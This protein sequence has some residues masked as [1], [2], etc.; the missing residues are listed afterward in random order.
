MFKA[1][2]KMQTSSFLC[3]FHDIA[4]LE[5]RSDWSQRL[6]T[7]PPASCPW[8]IATSQNWAGIC[9]R[10]PISPGIQLEQI[11]Q[12]L[13]WHL[14]LGFGSV[15]SI[16]FSYLQVIMVSIA[17]IFPWE[18]SLVPG[19]HSEWPEFKELFCWDPGLT[20][21]KLNFMMPLAE[22]LAVLG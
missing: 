13:P 14:V 7:M 5:L 19:Q 17:L 11:S 15:L 16:I 3:I 22:K 4:S 9:S 2:W 20:S 18:D 1:P 8:E 21:R 6:L 10:F 12:M